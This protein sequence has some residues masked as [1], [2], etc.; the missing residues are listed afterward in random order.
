MVRAGNT[1]TVITVQGLAQDPNQNW[2]TSSTGT[3]VGTASIPKGQVYLQASIDAR[4]DGSKQA[5]FSYSTDG[6]TFSQLG[7]AYTLSTNWSYFMGYRFAIFNLPR[8]LQGVLLSLS[9]LLVGRTEKLHASASCGAPDGILSLEHLPARE[10]F[11]VTLLGSLQIVARF[12]LCTGPEVTILCDVLP[13][14]PA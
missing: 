4:A 9:T 1:Y 11:T 2:A 6:K 3:V 8:R 5:T 14:I 10:D 7:G 13:C 12:S